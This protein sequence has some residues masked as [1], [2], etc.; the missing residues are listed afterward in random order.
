MLGLGVDH[1]Q[2]FKPQHH[3]SASRIG[4]FPSMTIHAIRR[5]IRQY[6]SNIFPLMAD[7]GCVHRTT[8]TANRPTCNS[9]SAVWCDIVKAR[10]VP[11]EVKVRS[12]CDQHVTGVWMTCKGSPP[13]QNQLLP[14]YTSLQDTCG[15]CR[16][17]LLTHDKL[18]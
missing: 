3:K 14:F 16:A 10:R 4:L 17:K 9:I 12:A 15:P 1:S 2:H 7:S 6:K 5:S 8:R 18:C 13:L 11:A